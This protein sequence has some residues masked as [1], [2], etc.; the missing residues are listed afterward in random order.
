MRR[1][2]VAVLVFV[3]VAVLGTSTARSRAEDSGAAECGTPIAGD[4]ITLHGSGDGVFKDQ[5][6]LTD[7]NWFYRLRVEGSGIV[8]VQLVQVR[9]TNSLYVVGEEAPFEET[10]SKRIYGSLG[11]AGAYVVEIH[12][13]DSASLNWQI[14]LSQSPV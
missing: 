7:G 5:I 6:E 14:E 2:L 8:T 13:D 4:V 9:G 1:W 3:S 11:E 12:A 10:G